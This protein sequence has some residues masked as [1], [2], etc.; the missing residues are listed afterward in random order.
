MK[1]LFTLLLIVLGISIPPSEA[2]AR[3]ICTKLLTVQGKPAPIRQEAERLAVTGWN[4][5]AGSGGPFS[6]DSQHTQ[7]KSLSCGVSGS[8]IACVAAAVPC[9]PARYEAC[10]GSFLQDRPDGQ[11]F[12][13]SGTVGAGTMSAGVRLASCDAGYRLVIAKGPDSCEVDP[14]WARR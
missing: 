2:L 9:A 13:G 11:D 8:S 7:R 14:R 12:C 6:W 10:R 1:A 5:R 4:V 3:D